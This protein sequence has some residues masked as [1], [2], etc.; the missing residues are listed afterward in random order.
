MIKARNFLVFQG[1]IESVAS[2]SPK[3]LTALI[4]QVSGSADLKKDYEDALKLRKECEEEQL[5]SLQRRKATTTLRKQ[6]KEQ[7]EEAEKHLRMQEELTKL[8]TE[9]VMFKLYH[10]DHEAERHT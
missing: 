10:I 9:H 6:M 7:K 5:A 8:R 2:K 3:D 1:D 4:E